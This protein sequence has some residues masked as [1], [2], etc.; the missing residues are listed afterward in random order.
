MMPAI[1][2][3]VTS[4]TSR[5]E[6]VTRH[7]SQS[8]NIYSEV[9]HNIRTAELAISRARSLHLKFACDGVNK[10]NADVEKFVLDLMTQD[11]VKVTGAAKGPVGRTLT[12]MFADAKVGSLS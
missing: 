6:N 7:S 8:A 2:Q 10:N 11:E 9:I 1:S 5:L 12:D 3:L 4:L